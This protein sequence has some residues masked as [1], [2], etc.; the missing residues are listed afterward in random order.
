MA[1]LEAQEAVENAGNAGGADP[2][3]TASC[4][5]FF[6]SV[7]EGWVGRQDL[8]NVFWILKIFR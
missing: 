2:K 1:D 3:T 8:G 6:L 5:D 4:C 7:A